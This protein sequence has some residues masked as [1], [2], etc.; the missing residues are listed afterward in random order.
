MFAST[1][2]RTDMTAEEWN[3]PTNAQYD[4]QLEVLAKLIEAKAK[5][6]EE[7]AQIVRDAKTVSEDNKRTK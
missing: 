3:M 6:V 1:F 5:T 2:V 7:A 4:A